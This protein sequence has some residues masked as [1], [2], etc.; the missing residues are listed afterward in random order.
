MI[1]FIQFDRDFP[2]DT[3]THTQINSYI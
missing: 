3:K 2:F 1:S